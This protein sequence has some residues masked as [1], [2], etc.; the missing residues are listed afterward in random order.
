[1]ASRKIMRFA[2]CMGGHTHTLHHDMKEEK[3]W[4]SSTHLPAPHAGAGMGHHTTC[5][6]TK[7]L[8]SP[9]PH[10]S[11]AP[12]SVDRTGP[13]AR[14][15]AYHAPSRFAAK[16]TPLRTATA[17]HR[18]ASIAALPSH[19]ALYANTATAGAATGE[20]HTC[21]RARKKALYLPHTPEGM[22]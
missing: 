10:H 11:P 4:C 16:D 13:L 5:A 12:H 1:M 8:L 17:Q 2:C 15:L 19:L 6:T 21:Q 9:L 18:A 22:A 7:R 3:S 14:A 20:N